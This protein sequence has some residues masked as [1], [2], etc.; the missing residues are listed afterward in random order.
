MLP[1]LDH[2][3][4]YKM[5]ENY[6]EG[7]LGIVFNQAKPLTLPVVA[8]LLRDRRDA[9]RDEPASSFITRVCQQVELMQDACA[10]EISVQQISKTRLRRRSAVESG[11]QSTLLTND[12]TGNDDGLLGLEE[13]VGLGARR[14]PDAAPMKPFEVVALSTLRPGTLEEALV[15]IPSLCCY[16]PNDLSAALTMLEAL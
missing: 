10:E 5:C 2:S 8:Q 9:A 7:D 14:G 12:A 11:L 4:T 6:V 16:D 3:S 15:L 1:H 13:E